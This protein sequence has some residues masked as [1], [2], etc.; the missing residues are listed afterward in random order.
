MPISEDSDCLAHSKGNGIPLDV[1]ASLDK[2]EK[3]AVR[4]A[5]QH[6]K[7]TPRT[8]AAETQTSRK[9]AAATLKGLASKNILLWSGKSTNDPK[10][11][12]NP[13]VESNGIAVTTRLPVTGYARLNQETLFLARSVGRNFLGKCRA[14]PHNGHPFCQDEKTRLPAEMIRLDS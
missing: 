5:A 1:F 7:V 10:V 6:E 2:K 11:H 4:L 3:A 9:T 8:L 13:L 12:L 14:R